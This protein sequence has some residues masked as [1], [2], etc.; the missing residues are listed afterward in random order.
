MNWAYPERWIWLC[1][2]PALIGFWIW[3]FRDR[4]RLLQQFAAAKLLPQM[5]GSVDWANRRLK[6]V[7]GVTGFFLLLLALLGPQWG[8]QWQKIQRRGVEM[9]IA[10]DVSK[11]M[12]AEDVKPNRLERAKLAIEEL[13]PILKG[14]RVG[15]IAFAG[16]AFVQCPLTVDYGAF[17]LALEELSVE[18]IPRGGTA[19]AEAIREGLKTFSK[20]TPESQA[21][22]LITDGESHEGNTLA[23]VRKAAAKG[24]KIFCIGIGTPGGELIPVADEEGGKNFLKDREGRPVKSRLDEALLQKV[25]LESGGSYFRATPTAFGLDLIYRERIAKLKT[26]EFE[27]GMRKRYEQRFQWILALALFF[28]GVEPFISERKRT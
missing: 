25:A 26:Q 13:L 14:D 12:L 23:V 18:T 28:L 1:L 22:V 21:L 4:N 10:L 20:A 5:A 24:I 16:T 27:S 8:F 17:S 9:V 19:L 7:L 2:V 6:T 11:S 15:L 3:A